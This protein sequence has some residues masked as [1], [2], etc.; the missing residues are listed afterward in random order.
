MFAVETSKKGNI[1]GFLGTQP[2]KKPTH[3]T[4]RRV[5]WVGRLAIPDSATRGIQ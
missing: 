3:P 5:G 4:R 1:L 2:L